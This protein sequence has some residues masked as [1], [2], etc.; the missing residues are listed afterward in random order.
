MYSKSSSELKYYLNGELVSI[1]KLSFDM[2]KN[3]RDLIIG[4]EF[5]DKDRFTHHFIGI[6]DYIAIWNRILSE[7]EIL[8]VS[9]RESF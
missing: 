3:D 9:R 8:K 6:I 4:A 5:S 1:K 2:Y 7:E